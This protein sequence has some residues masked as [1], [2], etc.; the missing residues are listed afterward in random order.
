M[1]Y[2]T[3]PHAILGK[4]ALLSMMVPLLLHQLEEEI[5]MHIMTMGILVRI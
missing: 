1:E 4:N 2:M 5:M 3:D